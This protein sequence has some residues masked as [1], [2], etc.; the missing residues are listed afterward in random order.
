MYSSSIYIVIQNVRANIETDSMILKMLEG[1]Q[2]LWI[3]QVGYYFP[4]PRGIFD[5]LCNVTLNYQTPEKDPAMVVGWSALE[6]GS[7]MGVG[8]SAVEMDSEMA[9]GWS[10]LEKDSEMM[11]GC[12]AH[13]IEMDW[14]MVMVL[15]CLN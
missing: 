7:E 14:S 15:G 11:V 9:V 3:S 8:W 6:K 13:Q 1:T 10:A 5:H 4:S 12:S 2:S